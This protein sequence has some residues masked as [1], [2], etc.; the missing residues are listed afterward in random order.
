MLK[1]ASIRLLMG[2]ALLL[3][4]VCRPREQQKLGIIWNKPASER[5]HFTGYVST[6]TDSELRWIWFLKTENP[7]FPSSHNKLTLNLTET[8]LW[9]IPRHVPNWFLALRAVRSWVTHERLSQWGWEGFRS[10]FL[11]RAL[12]LHYTER[13]ETLLR[14]TMIHCAF[15][16]LLSDCLTL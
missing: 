13:K 9:P 3:R 11:S 6:V 15:F 4:A 2:A 8:G 14:V 7:K 1:E 5:I 10:S 12:Q 16:P